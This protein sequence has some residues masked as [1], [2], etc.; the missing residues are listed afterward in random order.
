MARK[1]ATCKKCNQS[2]S[3]HLNKKICPSEHGHIKN[4]DGKY[5][6][7]HKACSKTFTTL[8]SAH[9]H[10]TSKSCPYFEGEETPI[11][12]PN[13]CGKTF[14]GSSAKSN[15]ISHSNTTMCPNH[16]DRIN[17]TEYRTT[18]PHTIIEG[19]KRCS[20][21]KAD[22]S[23]DQFAKKK[24]AKNDT[25]LD[26][27]CYK[28][29]AIRAMRQGVI[30]RAKN[31][32]N[33]YKEITLEYIKS[34]VTTNCPILGVQLQ[35]GGG[36]QCDN[37]ATIDAIIHHKGHVKGNLKIISKKA[38]TIKNN[39]T[40]EEMEMLVNALQ[41]WT[42]PIA[43]ETAKP[44]RIK[45]IQTHKEDT[46][47]VCSLCKE[48]K[49]LDMF[50]KSNCGTIL[51]VSNKCIRCTALSSMIKNAKQ[52]CK[53]SERIIDI[54]DYYLLKITKGLISCPVLGIEMVF[55]GTGS[56]KD[57]SASIDR[58]DTT[59]GYIKGNVWI[60]SYKANRMKS[61]ATIDDIK[62]VYDYMKANIS[63]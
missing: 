10:S 30:N 6:C 22:L 3:G 12:C 5:T 35:Y 59:K 20:D 1:D 34:L 63:V 24:N 32:G 48:T 40:S 47:K 43:D 13:K 57:N 17:N 2:L 25:N 33:D 37:S 21:C 51:G 19:K 23:L 26:Y 8:S 29:R 58:F 50:H 36:D 52:R 53:I 60:I 11:D 41:K 4:K 49:S 56:I 45:A 14:T 31:E 39:S 54:D 55:G 18:V 16:R 44:N 46:N 7:S 28:C 27:Y 42:P 38:N 9:K 15:A 62:K 61:D